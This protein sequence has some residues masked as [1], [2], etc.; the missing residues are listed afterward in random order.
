MVYMIVAT[1]PTAPNALLDHAIQNAGVQ[2]LR[3]R[4]GVWF[5]SV[6]GISA[7]DLRAYF[8]TQVPGAVFIVSKLSGA[9]ATSAGNPAVVNT[10][11]QNA[12][13]N[14]WF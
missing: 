8:S 6:G 13:N 5:I 12:T 11:F 9:W 10:F 2:W 14:G 4:E 1:G 7:A 3:A